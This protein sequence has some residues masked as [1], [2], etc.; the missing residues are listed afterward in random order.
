MYFLL[1]AIFGERES[2]F[3]M[4]YGFGATTAPKPFVAYAYAYAYGC[5]WVVA[6]LISKWVP[7]ILRNHNQRR[8]RMP[9][10]HM[11][12]STIEQVDTGITYVGP[13]H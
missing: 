6:Q 9:F 1:L 4:E 5:P 2:I 3:A 13:Q 7:T 12:T 8:N 11:Y 10:G